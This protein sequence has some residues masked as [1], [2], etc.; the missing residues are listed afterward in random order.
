MPM[1]GLGMSVGTPPEGIEAEL[2]VVDSFD[3]LERRS[4][5]ARGR[6]VLFN[7]PYRGYGPTVAYRTNG[8]SQAAQHGAVACWCARS[9]RMDCARRTPAC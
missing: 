8:A 1:L 9:A 7:V 4:A 2:L 3:E 6:I 5:E